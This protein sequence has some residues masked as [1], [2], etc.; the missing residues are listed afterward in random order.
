MNYIFFI[1]FSA[2][3][4]DIRIDFVTRE[5]GASPTQNVNLE[6]KVVTKIYPS[7]QEV[8]NLITAEH[9]KTINPSN[10]EN[11]NG[12]L[13]YMK[14]VRQL[15]IVDVKTGSLII[16][17]Q[18][19]SLH[20]LD[21]LW[22]DYCTGHLTEVAQKYLVTEDIL[23]DLGL[24]SVQLTLTINEEEYRAYRKHLLRNEG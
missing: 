10:P 14:E 4:L 24:D 5:Q 20:I 8:M 7:T 23:N 11:V 18:A 16:K 9:F 21:E 13:H 17:V 3:N 12:F 2:E 1:M 22:R 15:L 6:E 19:S